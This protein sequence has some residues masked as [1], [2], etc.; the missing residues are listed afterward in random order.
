M[1]L[2]SLVL[3]FV[4]LGSLAVR[5]FVG[6]LDVRSGILSPSRILGRSLLR[7][8]ARILCART[9]KAQTVRQAGSRLCGRRQLYV[10]VRCG[11]GRRVGKVRQGVRQRIEQ[12][13]G[14][15]VE[16][17][18]HRDGFFD[19]RR[20]FHERAR[21]FLPA[22]RGKRFDKRRFIHFYRQF[23]DLGA[24]EELQS[25]VHQ[26][27]NEEP[28]FEQ[29]AG[30][31]EQ[32]VIWKVLQSAQPVVFGIGFEQRR[33]VGRILAFFRKFGIQRQRK[34]EQQQWKQQ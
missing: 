30:K 27:R 1:V 6:V 8:L 21:V 2:R 15:F 22:R 18:S 34:R 7:V 4:V 33:F 11:F 19:A 29:H 23:Q 17:N 13:C 16:T 3:G 14:R 28:I 25:H 10:I 5:L 24:D 9:V 26:R 12:P 31:A 20:L 32:F